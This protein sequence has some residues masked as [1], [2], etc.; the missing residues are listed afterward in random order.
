MYTVQ[1]AKC[2]KITKNVTSELFSYLNFR[3]KTGQNSNAVSIGEEN[4]IYLLRSVDFLSDL[5]KL[6]QSDKK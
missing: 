2:L 1:Y 3:A 6:C 5:Q 4:R